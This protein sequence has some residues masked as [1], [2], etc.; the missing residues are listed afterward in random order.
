M[1]TLLGSSMGVISEIWALRGMVLVA[2]RQFLKA[3]LVA[4]KI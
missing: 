3:A 2:V 1:A 4:Y